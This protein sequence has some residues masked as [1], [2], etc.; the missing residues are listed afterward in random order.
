MYNIQQIIGRQLYLL[1]VRDTNVSDIEI[2]NMLNITVNDIL[3]Y[4]YGY[5]Q[6][7]D[8]MYKKWIDIIIKNVRGNKNE[9]IHM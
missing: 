6:I 7:P 3:T 5:K 1:R 4:E 2:A 9:N 8:I